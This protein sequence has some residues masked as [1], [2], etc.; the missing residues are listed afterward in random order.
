VRANVP[1]PGRFGVNALCIPKDSKNKRSAFEFIEWATTKDMMHKTTI[2]GGSTPC[3]LSVITD[4]ELDR[5]RWWFA[6]LREAAKQSR[7]YF[8]IPEWS[9]IDDALAIEFQKVLTD[10]LSAEEALE[11]ASEKAYA[12]LEEAGYFK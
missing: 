4:K 7:M 8:E 11:R 5:T 6:P 9:A 12:I 2:A 3:R 1:W 10:E